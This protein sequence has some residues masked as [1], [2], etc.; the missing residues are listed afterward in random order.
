MMK[1]IIRI[2]F[3]LLV[4]TTNWV[5]AQTD[6]GKDSVKLERGQEIVNQA[7]KAIDKGNVLQNLKSLYLNV[8]RTLPGRLR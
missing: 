7:R 5:Y 4:I 6:Y 8:D 3:F 2:L 1:L